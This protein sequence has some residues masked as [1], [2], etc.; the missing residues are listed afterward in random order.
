[1]LSVASA[2]V[3]GTSLHRVEELGETP[4]CEAYSH[5]FQSDDSGNTWGALDGRDLPDVVYNAL[6]FE[7]HPPFRLFVGG[8]AGV[9]MSLNPD[10]RKTPAKGCWASVAGNMPN[11]V[12]SD[13]VYH[14][15]D[16]IL[17]AATYGRGFWRLKVTAPFKVTDPRDEKVPADAPRA[18]GLR[19]DPSVQAPVLLAPADG[20]QFRNF[21][22]STRL[23]WEPVSG[24]IGYTVDV[25]GE[26]GPT[27]SFSSR[28][29]EVKFEFSGA[30]VGRWQ[31]WA[32][33]PLSA[34][35]PGSKVRTFRYLV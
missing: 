22:R 21:P 4:T 9:W 31:V 13:L 15:N 7:S 17:T 32:L 3:P 20:A 19:R 27:S 29:P 26:S 24:A 23:T 16:Q 11:V 35:S 1:V 30:G 10:T 8:D 2:G 25:S 5:V 14:H 34:R 6:V 33:L 12:V 18:A 28:T